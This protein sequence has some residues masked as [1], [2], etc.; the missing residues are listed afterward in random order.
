[1]TAVTVSASAVT[2]TVLGLA[3]TGV[4]NANA[5]CEVVS[6]RIVD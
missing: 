2:L 6:I 4:A 1:M 3:S 5:A